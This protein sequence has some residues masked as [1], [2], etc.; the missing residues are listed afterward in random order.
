MNEVKSAAAN[1]DKVAAAKQLLMDYERTL[2][3]ASLLLFPLTLNVS[4]SLPSLKERWRAVGRCMR[5]PQ[6][7]R[8]GRKERQGEGESIEY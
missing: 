7:K 3:E 6:D 1:E 8:G 4:V 2:D 5:K